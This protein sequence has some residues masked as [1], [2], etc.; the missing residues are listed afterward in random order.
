MEPYE[1]QSNQA[2][3]LNKGQ[4]KIV[5]LHFNGPTSTTINNM[6]LQ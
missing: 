4:T 2:I 5:N 3:G 6:F 1:T